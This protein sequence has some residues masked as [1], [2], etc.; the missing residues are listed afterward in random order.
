ML[1]NYFKTQYQNTNYRSVYNAL[2]HSIKKVIVHKYLSLTSPF[3]FY[4]WN[5]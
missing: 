5:S 4:L 3:F 1:F 2:K